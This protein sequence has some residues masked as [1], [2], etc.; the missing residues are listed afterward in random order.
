MEILG[1]PIA[2]AYLLLLVLFVL[3]TLAAP[4]YFIWF[5]LRAA[6]HLYHMEV[7]LFQIRDALR[8][9]NTAADPV[10]AA[11]EQPRERHVANSMFGR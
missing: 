6:R 11:L 3:A 5:T 2:G 10:Q 8:E 4:I 1:V 9:R 7:A